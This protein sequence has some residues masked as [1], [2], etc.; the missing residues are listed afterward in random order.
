MLGPAYV[1]ARDG[2]RRQQPP[3][4]LSAQVRQRLAEAAEDAEQVDLHQPSPAVVVELRGGNEPGDAGVGDDDVEAAQLVDRGA[5]QP[6]HVLRLRDV[7]LDRDRLSA[8]R[9]DLVEHR[10]HVVRVSA[11]PAQRDLGSGRGEH[12]R[13]GGADPGGRARDDR[14]L[15]VEGEHRRDSITLGSRRP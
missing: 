9:A 5:Q 8:L 7:R 2:A 1:R 10:L 3:R 12:P 14:G 11:V 4:P 6:P 15:P 13:G